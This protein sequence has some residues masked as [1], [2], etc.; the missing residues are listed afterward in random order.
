MNELDLKVSEWENEE[1]VVFF[2]EVKEV[3]TRT[4]CRWAGIP[5]LEGEVK[6]RTWEL[7][8]MVD[9]FGGSVARFHSGKK[10]GTAKKSG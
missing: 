4:G 9:S 10:P 6:Q 2:E 1:K 7:G 8:E 5:L 3:L